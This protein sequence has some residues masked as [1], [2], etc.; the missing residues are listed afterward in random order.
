MARQHHRPWQLT[1]LAATL[2]LAFNT[3]H[4]HAQQSADPASPADSKDA[5]T[6]KEATL[7]EIKA[8]GAREVYKPG[9]PSAAKVDAPPRDI[10]QTIT[11][12]PQQIIKDQ[13]AR[14]M[15]D[16][17]KT[18]PGVGLNGGDGQRDQV[19]IRGFTAIADQ[20]LDGLRDDALYYRDLSNIEQVEVIKGPAS[21]LYGRGSSGGLINRVTKKPRFTPNAE[22]GLLLGSDDEKRAEFDVNQPFADNTLALRLT[23]AVER[24]GSFR[25]QG[26]LNRESFAPSLLW[27]ATPATTV[28]LQYEQTRDLRVTDFGIPS[29]QGKPVPMPISTYYGSSDAR[30]DDYT[31]ADMK[32]GTLTIDHEF[33]PTLTLHNALRSYDYDLDRNNT[34]SDTINLTGSVPTVEMRRGNVRRAEHGWFNQTELKHKLAAGGM[35]HQMLYGIELGNQTKDQFF[36]SK[37]NV[38]STPLFAPVLQRP[39]F[40]IA[41]PTTD[42]VGSFKVASAYVQDLVTLSPQ[43]KTLAGLRYDRYT[44]EYTNRLPGGAPLART[45]TFLSPRLGVV[46]Q[47]D[48]VQSYY[49]SVTRSFQ[50]S[51]E[52]FAL[53]AN[54]AELAPEKT[55][56]LEVGAKYDWLGGKLSGGVSVFRL[57]RTD[58]KTTDPSNP[59]KLVLAG[60]Q[61][62]DGVEL[63]LAGDLG[64]GWNVYAGYAFL[65]A[66][67]TKSNSTVTVAYKTTPAQTVQPLQGKVPATVP[68][69]SGSLW[70]S[71]TLGGGFSVAGGLNARGSMYASNTNAVVLDSFITADLALFYRTK[72]WDV[73][74]NLK[75]ATDKRYFISAVNDNYSNPG[76]PRTLELSVR[77]RF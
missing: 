72:P 75:N 13:G 6:P 18:V 36:S 7:P 31:R 58:I 28:L 70:L 30:A 25:D 55:T 44:Q 62:T 76:A 14:S 35:E 16:V 4:A 65:D 38:Y 29:Y 53:A 37:S 47:P 43:W 34:V 20:F 9:T 41:T 33:S 68:R 39:P 50:P 61:Q 45:D 67:I 63:T 1:A 69:H 24:S 32:I 59:A 8:V 46:W 5:G 49:A 15:Q 19:T 48:A 73:A 12:V 60:E 51:G 17:L 64:S 3:A 71:K 11:V 22:I 74:L 42:G 23:G 54:N 26:F 77:Y 10:P 2:A 21:V 57:T 56:N 40:F 66:L 52:S 27:R